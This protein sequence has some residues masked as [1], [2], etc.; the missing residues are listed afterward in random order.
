MNVSHS[1][2][3]KR[4]PAFVDPTDPENISFESDNSE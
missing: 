1:I 2:L 4:I 3:D